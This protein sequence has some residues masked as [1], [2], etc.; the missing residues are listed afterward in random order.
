MKKGKKNFF[1]AKNRCL[2]EK[3]TIDEKMTVD[4][5]FQSTIILLNCFYFKTIKVRKNCLKYTKECFGQV[6]KR[7]KEWYLWH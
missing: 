1:A 7:S 5:I 2:Q 6:P 4:K 3:E